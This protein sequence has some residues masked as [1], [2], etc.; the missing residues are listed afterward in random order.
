MKRGSMIFNATQVMVETVF[1]SELLA[2]TH[3]LYPFTARSYTGF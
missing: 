3:R 2:S 1:D